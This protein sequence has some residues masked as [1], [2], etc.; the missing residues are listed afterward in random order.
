MHQTIF[1]RSLIAITVTSAMGISGVATAQPGV[2]EEVVVT[3][4]KRE[5]TNQEI[6]ISITALTASALEKRGI[7]NTGD[8]IGEIPAVG[9][10]ESPG[11]RGTTGLS[12]RGVAG[13]SPANLSV[14]PAVAIYL[15]GVYIGKQLGS[16][17]D[18][19][20]I[21]RIEVLRGPQGTLYGRNSTGGAVN[22]IT[23]RPSG[24][25]G[26]RAIGTV[27]DYDHLGLKLNVDL[28][29]IGEVGNGLGELAASLGYQTRERD[30][31]ADNDSPG[32]SPGLGGDS[33]DR[34]T[35]QLALD[36]VAESNHRRL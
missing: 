1:K 21:E 22:F 10:F 17:M 5:E 2:L 32:G 35:H 18:V 25:F 24:E 19:A 26:I 36:S 4:Q 15:D 14:D 31:L 23:R 3:A 20:E 34:S 28:P 29:A 12:M 16:A 11:A 9:G 7:Q 8:L 6:P 13:G 33:R 27:G 30:G